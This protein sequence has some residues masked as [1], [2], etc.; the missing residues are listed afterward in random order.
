MTTTLDARE[1]GSATRPVTLLTLTVVE[2]RKLVDTP[3]G[4]ALL[5]AGA[6]LAGVFGGGI[7]LFRDRPRLDEIATLAGMPAS[8]LVPVLAILLVTAERSQRTGLV[9]YAITP[10]R[11]RVFAAKTLAAAALGVIVTPL[12]LLA[13]VIIAPV[14][15][16]LTDQAAQWSVDP[17]RMIVFTVSNL[18]L[19]LSAVALASMIAN[20][21]AAI[22][23]VLVWPMLSSL[24]ANADPVAAEVISWIDLGTISTLSDSISAADL[25]RV[26]TAVALW[27]VLPG[28][29]G[30]RRV[31]REEVR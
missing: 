2:L 6:V 16:A 30:A 31:L 14:G 24:I 28:I 10:R 7:L 4:F 22:V 5:G 19:A 18:V 23:V 8:V 15:R 9:S 29:V 13:S 25:G 17:S 11:G 1:S 21:P 27:V 26:A 20:A 12:A 3:A